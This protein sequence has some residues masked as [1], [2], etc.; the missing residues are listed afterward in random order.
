[1]SFTPSTL[2]NQTGTV[3]LADNAANTP[4]S[5]PITANGAEPAVFLSPDSLTFTSQTDGTTSAPQTV[6]LQNYGNAP[7]TLG[8]IAVSAQ[9]V[10]STNGCGPSGTVL[11]AGSSCTVSVEFKPTGTGTIVGTLSIPDNAEDSPQ[12]VGLTGTGIAAATK[13]GRDYQ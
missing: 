4:Q 3:T 5:V 10:I 6:T 12:T 9:Y 2:E 1:V 7:L 8:T 11:A 13:S